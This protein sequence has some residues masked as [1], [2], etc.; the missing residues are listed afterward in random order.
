MA[1]DEMENF[2]GGSDQQREGKS[3]YRQLE[4]PNRARDPQNLN[5][6]LNF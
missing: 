3:F 6:Y 5:D 4:S 1:N 2:I